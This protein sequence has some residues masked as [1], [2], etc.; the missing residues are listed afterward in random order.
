M[1]K[2]PTIFLQ[3]VIMLIGIGALAFLV[4]EPRVEGV[5]ANATNFEMYSDPFIL[6][7][8]IGSIAFFTALYQA[9]TAL[10]YIRE[11][12]AFSQQVV[13]AMRTIRRCAF[14]IIGFVAVGEVFI[15]LNTSDDRAGGVAIRLLVA[16]GSIIAAS[17][18][19]VLEGIVRD[20]IS[21]KSGK[22]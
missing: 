22:D 16:F 3:A 11:G 12:K 13:N 14:V 19:A 9:F 4:W 18:A 17:T 5:N 10:R 21:A 15:M 20:G 7:A 2:G 6:F 8:Y 1:K